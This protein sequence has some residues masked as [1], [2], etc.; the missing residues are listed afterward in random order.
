MLTLVVRDYD[1]AIDFFTNALRFTLLEDTPLSDSKRRVRVAPA[2]SAGM[3]LLLANQE[4]IPYE[5]QHDCN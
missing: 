5:N 3:S 4:F 1:E 2:E